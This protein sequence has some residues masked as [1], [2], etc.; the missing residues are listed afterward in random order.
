MTGA[1]VVSIGV[2][3]LVLVIGAWGREIA[4]W[5]DRRR[6]RRHHCPTPCLESMRCRCGCGGLHSVGE[7]QDMCAVCGTL[8]VY[9]DED[10]DRDWGPYS[11]GAITQEILRP[12][13]P[14]VRQTSWGKAREEEEESGGHG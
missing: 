6:L 13:V 1:D 2:G 10:D 5:L 9:D 11:S 3:L 8:I 14:P 4:D 7:R 12:P